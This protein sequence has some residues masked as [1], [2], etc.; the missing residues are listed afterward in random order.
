MDITK[1]WGSSPEVL[2]W[3]ITAAALSFCLFL[4]LSAL[5]SAFSDWKAC[6]IGLESCDWLGLWRMFHFFALERSWVVFAVLGYN[7]SA[8]FSAI[9]AILL[10]LGEVSWAEKMALNNPEVILLLRNAAM[11]AHLYH[12]LHY[13]WWMMWYDSNHELFFNVSILFSFLH[14]VKI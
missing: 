12:L 3:A 7:Q 13:A 4:G 5:G 2:C 14:S 1:C 11:R 8:V 6:S 10:H 9:Q